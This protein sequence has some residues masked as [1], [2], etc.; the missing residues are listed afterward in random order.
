MIIE[1][2]QLEELPKLLPL[3]LAE[4]KELKLDFDSINVEKIMMILEGCQS[5]NG[6][7][8]ATQEPTG[9]YS[10][11]LVLLKNESWWSDSVTLCNLVFYV[12]EKFR[13]KMYG[14]KLLERAKE[15]AA[16]TGL[17]LNIFVDSGERLEEKHNL[18]LRKGFIHRGGT[19]R[20]KDNE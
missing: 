5:G 14:S 1:V 10:S 19:Y 2:T 18:F 9:E 16:Q 17:E 7:V 15:I 11:L 12:K 13:N 4:A 3:I 6:Y 20:Y 8:L